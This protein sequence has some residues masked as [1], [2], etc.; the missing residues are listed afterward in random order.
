[1]FEG[2]GGGHACCK[3]NKQVYTCSQ[4]FSVFSQ[5]LTVFILID[6][7][8]WYVFAAIYWWLL[9]LFDKAQRRA[10]NI[11]F[12]LNHSNNLYFSR[13]ISWCV[14]SM[15][16][17]VY[18]P[19]RLFPM[20]HICCSFLYQASNPSFRGKVPSPL[21]VFL[22]YLYTFINCAKDCVLHWVYFK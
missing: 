10:S 13:S 9:S 14:G 20:S 4:F 22:T 11:I 19:H 16:I 2:G 6:R 3:G 1:M 12:S 5:S 8:R 15:S 18:Q 21:C 7:R 17:C